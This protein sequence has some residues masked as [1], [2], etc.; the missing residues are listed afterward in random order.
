[1]R[2]LLTA[3][4]VLM[5][6]TLTLTADAPADEGAGF[7][8]GLLETIESHREELR[9][10]EAGQT[11][12][13]GYAVFGNDPPKDMMTG[14][15]TVDQ[16]Y[17]AHA[18]VQ[19]L[20]AE[21]DVAYRALILTT[22]DAMGWEI[23]PYGK[24]LQ[25]MDIPEMKKELP[26]LAGA[27]DAYGDDLF[28]LSMTQA[29]LH[30]QPTSDEL[31]A[32][33]EKLKGP[34]YTRDNYVNEL[35][36]SKDYK[37]AKRTDEEYIIDVL[38]ATAGR[39]PE[40]GDLATWKS[41]LGSNRHAFLQSCLA[42][43]PK[44]GHGGTRDNDESHDSDGPKI[45]RDDSPKIIHPSKHDDGP[46]DSDTPKI[47]HTPPADPD[48]LTWSVLMRDRFGNDDTEEDEWPG[49]DLTHADDT[50]AKD[51]RLE[52]EVENDGEY[53]L[54]DG[55]AIPL[56]NVEIE[57]SG[58]CTDSGFRVLVIGDG[59]IVGAAF[60]DKENTQS[61][62]F[63][64]DDNTPVG[65]QRGDVWEKKEWHTYKIRRV[66]NTIEAWCDGKKIVSG[67]GQAGRGTGKLMFSGMEGDYKI[68]DLVIRTPK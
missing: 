39:R 66:G 60:G 23:E 65:Q 34:N 46:K 20:K 3:A 61:Y 11:G 44:L 14:D 16:L 22:A 48:K 4:C 50:E 19:I 1:M 15:L 63:L 2:N 51:G 10:I 17:S 32:A 33:M 52:W 43:P 31:A 9:Q 59:G 18:R 54:Y 7:V 68:D 40:T 58:W 28:V 62:A 57:F 41:K 29:I 37:Q 38:Q 13:N 30:R 21:I 36:K 53:V 24:H 26:K 27:P 35:F 56:D 5:A 47:T 55:K 42:E 67:T 6:A 64:G 49:W 8:M 45:V 12:V 25:T